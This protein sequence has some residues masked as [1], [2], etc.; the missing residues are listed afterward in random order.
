[1]LWHSLKLEEIF[2]KLD[3]NRNG[4][5]EEEAKKRQKE[6]GLNKLPE[7]KRLSKVGIFLNQFKNPLIFI[8]LIAALICFFLKE[9]KDALVILAA[10]FLNTLIGFFQENK[11][12]NTLR[13]LKKIVRYRAKVFRSG[14]EKE[15]LT[16]DLVPG[17]IIII[18]AGD[19]VPADGR[20][21]EVHN[22]QVVE[23]VLTGESIPSEKKVMALPETTSLADREN[24]IYFG[25]NVVR[26][27]AIAVVTSIGLQTELGK[28]ASLI[29]ETKEEPTPLQ[30]KIGQLAKILG[31][32]IAGLAF[33][34]L[35]FGLLVGRSFGEMFLIAVAM[36]VAAI[37]ESL[38]IGMTICLALGMQRILKRKALVRKL[39]AAETLGSITV[40]A[41]DKTGT[42]TEGKMKV[43]EIFSQAEGEITAGKVFFLCN[44]AV[45]EN[46]DDEFNQWRIFGDPTEQALVLAAGQAGLKKKELDKEFPLVDEMPFDSEKMWMATLHK[47]KNQISNFKNVIFIKGAPERIL[48]MSKYIRVDEQEQELSENKYQEIEKKYLKSTKEG[49]RVLAGAYKFTEAK[50]LEEEDFKD[51]VFLG[52]AIL[53]DP[54]R[55]DVRETIEECRQAGLRPIIV[56]GDH[57]LTAQKIALEAGILKSEEKILEG[58]ELESFNKDELRQAVK[59][60]NVFSRVEPKHKIAIVDALQSQG[61]V[62]AMTGDGVNDAPAL[63]SA[64]IGI[65]LGSGTEVTKQTAD[66]VLLDDNFKTIVE[67]VK[68]GRTIFD[69]IKKIILYLLSSSFTEVILIG[70]SLIFGLPLPLLPAQILWVNI[71]QDSLPA[72]A[73]TN[74][75]TEKETMREKIKTRRQLLDKE[76][77]FLILLISL[78]TN[79]ILFGLFWWL[80]KKTGN[81]DYVRTII[82]VALGIASLFY[83]FSCKNLRK[84][85][86]HYFP[87]DNKFL[88]FS[89]IFGWLMFV[90]A[91]YIPFFQKILRVV[92]LK[93]TDWIILISFGLI[94]IILIEFGKLIFF[95]KRK[96]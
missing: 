22:L 45:I 21:I 94:N 44:D 85:I 42:L 56:T 71:I 13:E 64:D 89:V 12:E 18:E 4:L 26:G 8:L 86:F 15:T 62:V 67:A 60:I 54:L 29:K 16:D 87:L 24:M 79:L 2:K 72:M 59:E 46:P 35:I 36:T 33:L 96:K 53:R 14:N 51:F 78:V 49:L 65:A 66:M 81:L 58:S 95:M 84:T 43:E 73:L 74:E 20:L 90:I 11:A 39:I 41:A 82:F 6:F 27:K 32:L 37:P 68:E 23:A 3:T 9:I 7:E 76:M 40:I 61:E 48:K 75:K 93:I 10:V 38:V 28:I 80:Y 5:T 88:N 92:P 69:N 17:D 70:G 63:K 50:K 57:K 30:K 47:I 19:I 91:F 25:T 55:K 83:I 31:I 52:L 77:K 1:M 34:I